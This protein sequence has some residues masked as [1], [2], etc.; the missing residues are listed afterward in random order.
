[1]NCDQ[2]WSQGYIMF[3]DKTRKGVRAGGEPLLAVQR[4]ESE[5]LHIQWKGFLSE[6]LIQFSPGMSQGQNGSLTLS[7]GLGH[8]QKLLINS[9][10]RIRIG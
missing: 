10:G 4:Y 9:L 5:S 6:S 7:D 8:Q 1:M 3:L 2:Q